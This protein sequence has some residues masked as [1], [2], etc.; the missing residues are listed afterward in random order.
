MRV[1][2]VTLRDLPTLGAFDT[3]PLADFVR[4]KEILTFREHL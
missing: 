4:D 2:V 1:H 3:A